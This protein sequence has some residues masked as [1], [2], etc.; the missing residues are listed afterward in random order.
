MKPPRQ[1]KEDLIAKSSDSYKGRYQYSKKSIKRSKS[2]EKA[3]EEIPEIK[4]NAIFKM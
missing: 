4:V 2:L 3:L 1:N